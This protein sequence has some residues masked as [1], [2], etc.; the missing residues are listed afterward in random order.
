MHTCI[1]DFT[2][3]RYYTYI[4]VTC[5]A[6][7]LPFIRINGNHFFLLSFVDK[8]LNL[9]FVSFDTQELYLMPFVLI[10]LFLSIFL[11]TTLGG[12]IW[13]AWTCPQ[14][15]FRVIYRDLIQTKL[16]KIYSGIKNKQKQIKGNFV[17][18]I[19]AI[20]IF[21]ILAFLAVSNLLWYFIPPEQ[22]FVYLQNPSEHTLFMGI[23]IIASLLFT[24]DICYLKEN[25]CIYVCP[26]A[27][28]QST[29]FDDDTVQVIYDE[30]RGGKIFNGAV[31]LWKKP[32]EG[33]CIGCEACVHVCPTHI[34][35]RRGMQLECINCLECADACSHIQAK[36][37]RPSLINWT[38][39]KA[40][41][42]KNKVH[43]FRF[44]TV[45]YF[46]V[47]FILVLILSFVSTK[48]EHMLLNINRSSEL[49]NVSKDG[50]VNNAYIFLFQNTDNK[51][52]TYY[53]DVSLKDIDGGLKITKPS[54]PF[55]LKAGGKSKQ[56]VVLEATQNLSQNL[57]QD[58]IIPLKIV[59]YATDDKENIIVERESIFVYP[60]P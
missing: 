12:R 16:L 56:I 8:K 33:E 1:T 42:T 57:D 34:D 54:K 20:L 46:V 3:K 11:I 45:A 26:Y 19:L 15:I 40:L 52:H 44:R 28:I 31:K 50:K 17:K 18:R 2:K 14:T 60:K 10:G 30:Q 49:Y 51:E 39:S 6:F 24:L 13:C 9:L 43:Y 48:K 53:F 37:N 32:P 36:F 22:F 21:Y 27:R 7:I 23:L 41:Q 38:S 58:T 4:L 35:I 59:A 55:T 47:L 25:F 5:I 29:M